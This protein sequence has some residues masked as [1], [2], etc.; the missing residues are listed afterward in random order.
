[1]LDIGFDI[2]M[3]GSSPLATDAVGENRM[4]A[5][6]PGRDVYG[7]AMVSERPTD[8]SARN[9]AG[10]PARGRRGPY[11]KSAERRRAIVDAAFDVFAARGYLAGSLQE[12]ADQVGMSQTSLLHYFP[13]KRQL[14]VAVL[15]R[16]DVLDHVKPPAPHPR[17]FPASL[18]E[19]CR[20][21]EAVPTLVELYTVLCGEATTADH[22]AREYFDRRFERIRGEYADKLRELD[23]AGRL[24][25]GVDV[26]RAAASI[27]ALWDGIQSQWL[28]DRSVDMTA[29]LSDYLNLIIRPADA[30]VPSPITP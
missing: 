1:M 30:P 25:E 5:F 18:V 7:R 10:V 13:T 19:R 9:R 26:E 22:P 2:C 23:A 17:D 21:N 3:R 15:D 27:I 8:E 12:I 29:C 14:L 11:T 24:R 16:R 28:R 20:L 4:W 6:G